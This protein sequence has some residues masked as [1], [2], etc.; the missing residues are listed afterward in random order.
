MAYRDERSGL[1]VPAV[2][3]AR[4]VPLTPGARSHVGSN[5]RTATPPSIQS[6]SAPSLVGMSRAAVWLEPRRLSLESLERRILVLES[7]VGELR[8]HLESLERLMAGLLASSS[9]APA[10]EQ[11]PA[12]DAAEEPVLKTRRLA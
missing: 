2:L 7:R 1:C 9:E 12:A 3:D 10:A 8:L 5:T 11:A 6:P 4:G